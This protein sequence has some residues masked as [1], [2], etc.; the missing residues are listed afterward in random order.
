ML[1]SEPSTPWCIDTRR[2]RAT[3]RCRFEPHLTVC[4]TRLLVQV[5]V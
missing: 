4:A 5:P 3:V 2:V 1:L